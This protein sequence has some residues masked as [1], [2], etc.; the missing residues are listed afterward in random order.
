MESH[1]HDDLSILDYLKELGQE[2][3]AEEYSKR[4]PS[5]KEAFITQVNNLEK[6]YPGGLKEY[7]KRAKV[8][9]NNSKNNINPYAKY[10][11][12]VP[13]GVNVIAG[14]ELFYKY[15]SLGVAEIRY[16]G[17][18]LVAGGL[19][20]RL[21]Y[22]DIKIGIPSELVTRR[23]Y[24]NLYADYLK[25]YE[26]KLK[27]TDC[28]I[29][30][31]IMTSDD[32]HENTIKLLE[33]H[34]YFG[35]KKEQVTIVK[36]EKVPAL[37]DNDC[38][39]ALIP[40]KLIID[41][42]PHGHGDVHT[43]LYQHGVIENWQKLGKRWV[44]FF[45]DTNALV[46][47]AV[48]SALGVSKD[49]GFVINS[50][51]IPRKPAEAVGA[52]CK[53]TNEESGK[54]ITLNVEYN[55]LDSLLRDKW[56]PQGDVTN[57]AGL[58]HFPGNTNVLVFQLEPFFETLKKT[59]GLMPEFVNPKYADEAKNL[60]KS[61]TRLECMMQDYPQLLD[62]NEKV[63]F[64]MFEKWFVFSACKN[65]LKDGIDKLKKNL[66]PETA[67]S[68]EQDIFNWN[69]RVLKDILGVLKIEGGEAESV[70]VNEVDIHF[71]P[72]IVIH[73]SFAFTL[74]CLKEK[75]NKLTISQDSTLII[76]GSESRIKSLE[77]DGY[78][79][80]TNEVCEERFVKN[81]EKVRYVPLKEGEGENYEIIRGYTVGLGK[82]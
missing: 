23:V 63:G 10:T 31:C 78:L 70:K 56:N 34:S 21:G 46:F 22:N 80:V 36:Q 32:T 1:K 69:V 35:L 17:F 62:A 60:F 24:F 5:E 26:S 2:H 4:P 73:P 72:K 39:F 45:Q 74:S 57:D 15:E 51:T 48:P 79:K 12:S 64:T 58:S 38:H 65:N 42:K 9:L 16:T 41:T 52:I 82:H 29:P 61:P 37:L 59:K 50:I 71:G 33:E 11:P 7:I 6:I 54:T 47:N 30:L 8:L 81:D 53:L 3:I 40:E 25:A 67:F 20:E 28:F 44:V 18:V 76:E 49:N 68:V 43:L 19:G 13:E 66:N 55:Q 14:D 77:L 75:I 27:M